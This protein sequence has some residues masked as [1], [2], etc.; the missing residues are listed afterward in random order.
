MGVCLSF[1]QP[2][3]VDQVIE[4]LQKQGM[5]DGPEDDASFSQVDLPNAPFLPVEVLLPSSGLL[6]NVRAIRRS[7]DRRA[8][9][10]LRKTIERGEGMQL[11][12]C[13]NLAFFRQVY[14]PL[15]PLD[16]AIA[17]RTL[18]GIVSGSDGRKR[19]LIPLNN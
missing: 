12:T 15:L 16:E 8:F 3:S 2:R 4:M 11:H 1:F 9:A 18:L 5:S 13:P 6:V 17:S 14:R 19:F 7:E 10:L